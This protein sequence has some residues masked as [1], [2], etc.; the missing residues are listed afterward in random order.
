MISDDRHVHDLA[1][2][3]QFVAPQVEIEILGTDTLRAECAGP[4]HQAPPDHGE[5]VKIIVR[6]R[7]RRVPGA[8]FLNIIVPVLI[9][10]LVPV[11]VDELRVRP[12]ANGLDDAQQHLGSE[13]V[14]V[15]EQRDKYTAGVSQRSVGGA[16]NMAVFRAEHRTDARIGAGRFLQQRADMRG[17]GGVVGETEFPARIALGLHT[18]DH[19]DQVTSRGVEHRH[20]NAYKRVSLPG[21]Y[22]QC[23]VRW[24]SKGGEGFVRGRHGLLL[25][26][27]WPQLPQPVGP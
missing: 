16:G 18:C 22:G 19:L 5:M 15:V 6:H 24:L 9:I 26:Q 8:A 20:Q 3:H 12:G 23:E 25:P 27:A 17:G 4:F 13:P 2:L 21:L 11:R 7:H 14:V 1:G 10:D